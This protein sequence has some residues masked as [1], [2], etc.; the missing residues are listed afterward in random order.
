[1]SYGLHRQKCGMRKQLNSSFLKIAE[2]CR[3][4][5]SDLHWLMQFDLDRGYM[6]VPWSYSGIDADIC[7]KRSAKVVFNMLHNRFSLKF[8]HC[9]LRRS[10]FFSGFENL[11]LFVSL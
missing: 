5:V 2:E 4:V 8:L 10:S 3:K 1:M 9:Q 7:T 11:I 6:D